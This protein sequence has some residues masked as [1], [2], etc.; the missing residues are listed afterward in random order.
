MEILTDFYLD[1]QYFTFNNTFWQ[2]LLIRSHLATLTADYGHFDTW[3][4][5][6]SIWQHWR[7]TKAMLKDKLVRSNLAT[8]TVFDSWLEILAGKTKNIQFP[9]VLT[10]LWNPMWQFWQMITIRSHLA[11]LRTDWKFWQTKLIWSQHLTT[12]CQKFYRWNQ[13]YLIWHY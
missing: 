11:T 8:S 3:Y 9:N 4:F 5:W 2:I 10:V 1:R 7:L 12:D 6:E 13:Y